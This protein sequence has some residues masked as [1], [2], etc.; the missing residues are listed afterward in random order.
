MNNFTYDPQGLALTEREEALRLTSY[1]DSGLVPSN[2]YGHTGSDVF[3]PGQVIT[4]EQAV[5]WLQADLAIAERA[6]QT[7][8]R[9]PLMQNQYDA[10][11]DFAYNAGGL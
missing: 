10:L 3:Y 1:L 4:K 7:Y 9:V 11:V 8:V 2:G 6:V 5:T